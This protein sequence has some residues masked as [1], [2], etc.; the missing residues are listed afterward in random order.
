[1]VNEFGFGPRVG[2]GGEVLSQTGNV[3]RLLR[4]SDQGIA[5]IPVQA[6]ERS[7]QVANVRSNAEV[8][9]MADIDDD[10]QHP[11]PRKLARC[12]GGE[13]PGVQREALGEYADP[14]SNFCQ[15]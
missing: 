6:S 1:M 11:R 8:A 7:N 4:A 3:A 15:D 10:V 2:R 9:D 14:A 12:R 5:I 13:L